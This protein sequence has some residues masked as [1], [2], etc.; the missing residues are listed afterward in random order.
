M[1]PETLAFDAL[2]LSLI[3]HARLRVS[4]SVYEA[5]YEIVDRRG[6][7]SRKG[8]AQANSPRALAF[9]L[10]RTI[11]DA[12]GTLAFQSTPKGAIVEI[13]GKAIGVT[14][15]SQNLP[16]GSYQ[17]RL[18]L[19]EFEPFETTVEVSSART[20]VI[21]NDLTPL[22]GPENDQASPALDALHPASTTSPG[23]FNTVSPDAIILNNYGARLSYDFT[24]QSTT[25]RNA[26]GEFQADEFEF[27][28]FTE[29][30]SLPDNSMIDRLVSPH[31]PRLELFYAGENV[32]LTLLSLSYLQS[33]PD[34]E[35]MLERRS[36]RQEIQATVTKLQRFQLRPFQLSYRMFF[37]NLVP[38]AEAGIGINFQW[39][40]LRDHQLPQP[41]TL[42]QTE[43]FWTAG[44]GIQYFFN[45]QISAQFRYNL[46]SYFN[47][48][49][50]AEHMLNFGVG[51][52][53]NNVFGFEAEPPGKL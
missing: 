24:F 28:G 47:E 35:A 31:G 38:V 5:D 53:F 10:V 13:D 41:I 37:G 39:I 29:Q 44:L 43:A 2:N 23:F 11:F 36:D 20:S 34:L 7:V 17:V 50:G 27:R 8:S 22:P 19:S 40:R 1:T 42:S 21:Q 18:V 26:R 48:G 51:M 30:A 32:G 3:I 45:S 14:P 16:V 9:D 4:N 33:S 46:Q 25:F 12:T 15:I 6:I 52:L 49:L